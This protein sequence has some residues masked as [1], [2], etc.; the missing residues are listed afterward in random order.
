MSDRTAE[1]SAT[2]KAAGA[3]ADEAVTRAEQCLQSARDKYETAGTHGW[4][5]VAGNIELA[6]ESLEGVV[7][8]LTS[9][10]QASRTASTVL[11]EITD[12]MSSPEVAAHLVSASSE[13]DTAHGAAEAS[14]SLIDEAIG[15]CEAAGQESLPAS[16]NGL[17]DQVVEI[18]ERMQQCR[19]DV[20][21][22]QQEAENFAQQT[23]EDSSG[24]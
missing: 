20:D 12:K 18:F 16:L 15:H 9:A 19:T 2:V 24:N 1:I 17:R 5:G 3:G 7:E 8:Q 22:E 13:L 23:D 6:A 10:E 14:I 21:A 4:G 11:D